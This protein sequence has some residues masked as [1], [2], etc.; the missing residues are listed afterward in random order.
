[1]SEIEGWVEIGEIQWVCLPSQI[2]YG[3][4]QKIYHTMALPFDN[5]DDYEVGHHSGPN[6]R[7]NSGLSDAILA[8]CVYSRK[9]LR[10]EMAWVINGGCGK[11]KILPY[12]H[13]IEPYGV[14]MGGIPS[15]IAYG[16]WQK[17]AVAEP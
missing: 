14:A 9:A 3:G 4:W 10:N 8:L 12:K 15:Q 6:S 13:A 17:S 7:L 1:M 16:G 5:I 11:A 2:A